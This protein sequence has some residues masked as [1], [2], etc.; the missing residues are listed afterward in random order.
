MLLKTGSSHVWTT[1]PLSRRLLAPA[2]LVALLGLAVAA[3]AWAFMA[4]PRVATLLWGF[5]LIALAAV[6]VVWLARRGMSTER[7]LAEEAAQELEMMR[8]TDAD[9]RAAIGRHQS[10]LESLSG[11]FVIVDRFDRY[12]H[13]SSGAA[14]VLGRSTMRLG[15]SLANSLGEMDTPG[16]H[17]AYRRAKATRT[18]EEL[19]LPCAGSQRWLA[20]RIQPSI[21]T[22]TIFFRDVTEQRRTLQRVQEAEEAFRLFA[23][24]VQDVFW[25]VDIPE[26][27]PIYTSPSWERLTGLSVAELHERPRSALELVHRDDR[28][29]V[30]EHL[31]RCSTD[32]E[33]QRCEVE[34]R[35]V[36]RDGEQR[37]IHQ[38]SVAQHDAKG[39]VIRIAGFASDVT[40]RKRMEAS[41]RESEARFRS[42]SESSPV[43]IFR[44]DLQHRLIDVNARLLE[45][46]TRSEGPL[47]GRSL[48]ALVHEE[49]REH[50]LDQ[51][52]KLDN[53]GSWECRVGHA[54]QAVR[55]V[56]MRVA[57]ERSAAG[58]HVGYIGTLSDLTEYREVQ[59]RLMMSERMAS[60]GT[61]AAGV[62][63]E[64]NNPLTYLMCNLELARRN[65]DKVFANMA[66]GDERVARTSDFLRIAFEGSCRIRDIVRELRVFARAESEQIGAVD[67]LT[68]VEAALN[69]A[70]NQVRHRARIVKKLSAVPRVRA[71]ETRLGQVFLNLIVN[72]AQAIPEGH[73]DDNVLTIASYVEAESA[74]VVVEISDT[75]SG[76]APELLGRIFDPF[77]T[78]KSVGEGTGLGLFLAQQAVRSY[79]GSIQVTSE[80]G[81]G[82]T[83]RV[84]LS[85]MEPVP[86][87][88]HSVASTSAVKARPARI[89]VIDD[90]HEVGQAVAAML[91]T[92]HEV[93]TAEHGG[94]ALA[95][96]KNAR[97][98]LVLC[99]LM[100]PTMS[101]NEFFN[102]LK[103]VSPEHVRKV[104]FMTGGVFTDATRAFLD[105]AGRPLINKPF[106]LAGLR[107]MV[108]QTIAEE[109]ERKATHQLA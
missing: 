92:E 43:G 72:A 58:E 19:E 30:C 37:W 102:E 46:C 76:I 95:L 84:V 36:R 25:V 41:L 63:H 54:R 9:L 97:F 51:L 12:I 93:C 21:D 104:C 106:S 23:E 49:D 38:S 24:N 42:L 5:T 11:G 75:G 109:L 78:T 7:R 60:L 73:A 3:T 74:R 29:R 98:D 101:A 62:G 2:S 31:L 67:A 50:V 88:A 68:C 15:D 103:R 33:S 17:D 34:F 91:E 32:A 99:D 77:F 13:V 108:A 100:M 80:L 10:I 82:S 45:I 52:H 18:L 1:T 16:F 26:R 53:E 64:I 22:T 89:L 47:A 96:L 39:R 27:R 55:T 87:S 79:G 83:F 14:R 90:E 66:P 69:I 107:A 57:R 35:I 59:T 70:Q 40:A 85:A 71:D 44:I 56:L 105:D 94:D 20:T 6:C 86:A 48:L 81:K 8:R 4:G 28:Q 61:L 65:V